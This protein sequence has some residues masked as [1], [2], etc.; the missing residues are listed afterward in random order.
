[1][2]VI[3]IIL[4]SRVGGPQL[5]IAEV[6][7]YLKEEYS[8]E[9]L[10]VFPERNSREYKKILDGMGVKYHSFPLHK[11]S[12]NLK[13]FLKWLIFLVPE[14][15]RLKKV[16]KKEDPLIVHCNCSWQWKGCWLRHPAKK[17][18]CDTSIIQKFV[19]SLKKASVFYLK[20]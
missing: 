18:W 13:D 20:M 2:K 19:L 9:T 15:R 16:I 5:R 3:N 12:K 1:M 10:V 11:L 8:I 6:A 4:E 17:R 7:K 14:I